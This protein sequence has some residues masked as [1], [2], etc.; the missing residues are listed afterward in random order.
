M[1]KT[2]YLWVIS[3]KT[4]NPMKNFTYFN[5]T[6]VVLIGGKLIIRVD[7]TSRGPSIKSSS[8][9]KVNSL[10]DIVEK[11]ASAYTANYTMNSERTLPNLST[12]IEEDRNRASRRNFIRTPEC[13]NQ[14]RDP[15][16]FRTRKPRYF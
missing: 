5:D 15:N 13:L 10:R 7:K 8:F 12:V 16:L 14:R 3:G 1:I 4:M 9:S 6:S 2:K 11:L